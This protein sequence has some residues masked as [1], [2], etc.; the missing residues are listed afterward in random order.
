MSYIYIMTNPAYEGY[1]KIGSANDVEKRRKELSSPS[2]VMFDF[3]VYAYY[4]TSNDLGD[5][6]LHKII[7]TLKPELRVNKRREFY[8]MSPLDAYRL[9]E[10]IA[11]ING[12]KDKLV[13]V[14][15][16]D[17]TTD[18][19]KE[20]VK[21][22]SKFSFE[23]AGI[24]IGSELTFLENEDIKVKVINDKF[25]KIEYN[26]EQYSLSE[27]AQL[28]LETKHPVQ[29]TLYFKYENETLNDRRARLEVEGKYKK[30]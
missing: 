8:K 10:C 16:D 11:E 14:D 26:G 7:D 5:I 4:E 25:K 19:P 22:K 9:L 17:D 29:G 27:L 23:A 13:L 20:K 12:S 30:H 3:E 2:G 15:D 21:K 28:L 1:V 24:P 6:K 18:E